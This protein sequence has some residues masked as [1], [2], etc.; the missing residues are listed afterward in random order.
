MKRGVWRESKRSLSVLPALAGLVVVIAL[1]AVG[2]LGGC[3]ASSSPQAAGSSAPPSSPSATDASPA[4]SEKSPMKTVGIIGGISWVSTVQYYRLINEM[5]QRQLGPLYS[6]PILLYSIPF[7]EFS[8]QERLANKGDWAPLRQTM[9][10]AAKRL[11]RGGADFIIVASNTMNS[12]D[13]LIE[14]NVDIPVLSIIDV[15][16]KAVNERGLKTVALL[17][18][19]YTMEEDFYKGRLQRDYGLNVVTPNASERDYINSVIFDELCAGVFKKTSRDRFV[20]FIDRL[21][22]EEGAEGVILG[23]TEIPL[24]M[25]GADTYVPTFDTTELHSAAAMWYLMGEE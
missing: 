17:G 10:E 9:V 7:G 1:V 21:V 11:E 6:A 5:V 19:K 24:L 8:K 22:Q 20:K 4:A 12:T 14:A 23:C 15:V 18:T 3:A 16:G 25:K 2:A 13:D